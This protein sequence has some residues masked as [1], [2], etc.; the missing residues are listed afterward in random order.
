MKLDLLNNG[1]LVK[2]KNDD[3]Y[4]VFKIKNNIV[5][6]NKNG[7]K[8][9]YE[10]NIALLDILEIYSPVN[11]A[12]QKLVMNG[13]YDAALKNSTIKWMKFEKP[14]TVCSVRFD[15]SLTKK[16]YLF[17]LPS[18]ITEDSKLKKVVV[19]TVNGLQL[20]TIC[21][22]KK[23]ECFEDF[24]SYTTKKGATLPLKKVVEIRVEI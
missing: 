21:D 20:A 19:D 7:L 8:T 23:L 14:M 22:I 6:L 11:M 13:D 24:V 2:I 3:M 15:N 12:M 1:D 4:I 16:K 18:E 17:E 9:V 5:F 10:S